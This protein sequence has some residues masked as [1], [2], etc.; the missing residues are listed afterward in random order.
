M[1]AGKA[2]KSTVNLFYQSND[3]KYDYPDILVQTLLQEVLKV[4]M[5]LNLREE[6]SGVYGVGVSVSST[7]IPNPLIRSRVSFSCAPEAADFLVKQAQL[8]LGKVAN[9]PDYFAEDLKNIKIQQIDGYKKQSS[10]NLFWSTALRNQFYFGFKDFSYFTKY[11]EMVNSITPAQIAE[12][13][14]KYIINQPGIKAI[15][16]PENYKTLNK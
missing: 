7:S 4:K 15:L 9:K 6:N 2:P 10:K 3:V 1:Y 13:A 16:M 11:E 14:K 5:R 8:E 12:Y